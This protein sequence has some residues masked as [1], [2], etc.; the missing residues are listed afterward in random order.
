MN[1][2]KQTEHS[3]ISI[4]SVT[5]VISVLL[6]LVLSIANATELKTI[7]HRQTQEYMD[8]VSLQVAEL[9]DHR[10]YKIAEGLVFVA[11]NIMERPKENLKEYLTRTEQLLNFKEIILL[12]QNGEEITNH[13]TARD[14]SDV[15]AFHYSMLGENYV[16][17]IE[18]DNLMYTV[19][20]YEEGTITG[21]LAGIKTK[22][23]M[24]D[25]IES[26]SF[27]GKSIIGI[28]DHQGNEIIIS[29]QEELPEEDEFF[30]KVIKVIPSDWKSKL[31]DNLSNHSSGSI[32]FYLKNG[33]EYTMNYYPISTY[34]WF[35]FTVI[36][37]DII[38]AQT[39]PLINE[40]VIITIA[41]VLLLVLI[42]CVF[43][44]LQ[45][46]N[47]KN[48]E[49]SQRRYRMAIESET[50]S[51]LEY[52]R[53][54]D[55]FIPVNQNGHHN[56]Q[57]VIVFDYDLEADQIK[58]SQPFQEKFNRNTYL[59]HVK[60]S[61]KHSDL[62]Y[63]EDRTAIEHMF[64]QCIQHRSNVKGNIRLKT[65]DNK[66]EWFTL[67]A[68][69][70]WDSHKNKSVGIIGK[71]INIHLLKS[72]AELW[73]EKANCDALTGL[74]NREA[75]EKI[76]TRTINQQNQNTLSALVFIDVDNFKWVND[77][78]GH[79]TGD[80][81]LKYISKRL[82][83]YFSDQNSIGRYGGD[84]FVVFLPDI[85]SKEALK[86][87][88][89]SLKKIF[90]KEYQK[91][92]DH[93]KISGSIGAAICFQDASEYQDLIECADTALYYAKNN[94]KNQCAFYE[95]CKSK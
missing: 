42:L 27:D 58:F 61:I 22:D 75:F 41:S 33:K 81:V 52:N 88:L 86:Q 56:H 84:E 44:F 54:T 59:F 87:K 37:T 74:L 51:L 60:E 78:L 89:D 10:T 32:T 16:S 6:V 49:R 18:D 9:V 2:K 94:G 46:K 11:D 24:A 23:K 13:S 68:Q 79:S 20:I 14:F 38:F 67:Y 26:S 65:T 25:L 91:G 92:N 66:Y 64:L 57:T 82:K 29:S 83:F 77:N 70:L 21:V 36:P 35:L 5:L 80:D 95:D 63:P 7:L 4:L 73:K 39:E 28:M 72:E 43:V 45:I 93:H 8:D 48:L 3:Y 53:F 69:S 62:I 50:D 85:A 34:N 40:A 90:E 15:P 47:F 12:D 76:V 71:L 17:A 1:K 19:P 30:E 31:K 55:Q